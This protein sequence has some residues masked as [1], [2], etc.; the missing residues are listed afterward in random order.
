[1]SVNVCAWQWYSKMIKHVKKQ[2]EDGAQERQYSNCF[3]ANDLTSDYNYNYK[4]HVKTKNFNNQ[5]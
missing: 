2:H 5:C 1:M 3:K 4:N